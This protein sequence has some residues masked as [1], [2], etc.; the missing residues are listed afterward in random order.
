MGPFRVIL[1]NGL[2]MLFC[3][4]WGSNLG[5]R[6]L[7]MNNAILT[8]GFSLAGAIVAGGLALALG[9]SIP[10]A[11]VAAMVV[12][13]AAAQIR[14]ALA[15]AR[16]RRQTAEELAALKTA[17]RAF[18]RA[19]EESSTRLND[20]NELIETRTSEQRRKVVSELQVLESLMR[21]F[22]ANLSEKAKDDD[23][24]A[25]PVPAPAAEATSY[26]EG[27]TDP[28][29]LEMI[30]TSL[31]QNRVDLYLQP[32]VSLPQRKLRFYEA[33]SRLRAEDGTVIMPEQY[34]RVAAPAGL[35][36]V[37]D[38]LLLFRCVQVVRKLTQKQRDMAV[39]CNIA[40]D[41]LR[42]GE[43][44]PQFL[45]YMHHNRDLAGHIVFEFAQSVVLNADAQVEANLAYLANMGFALSMDH[46]T[47]LAMDLEKLRRLGFRH[48]KVRAET[49]T[50]GMGRA[51]AHVA[52]EDFK[53]LLARY[54][55]NL[56]AERVETEKTV[57]ELLDYAVDYAQGFLFGEPRPVR[58]D[59]QKP[60]ERP[61][62]MA[63]II[64]LRRAG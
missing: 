32:I 34:M 2:E 3:Q 36:S 15:G 11:I 39:F 29:L 54:S 42:D 38:N 52:A 47:T 46:V 7:F 17:N 35:M 48:I 63:A 60:A 44:F 20:L 51:Q 37:V 41:T 31:E 9:A 13:L 1:V 8:A 56:I 26:L 5:R 27:V 18:L 45:D 10:L 49:L 57:V 25:A 28:V 58:D 6:A 62:A 43:F 50:G 12:V 59:M 30:R 40:G 19:A 61:D 21:D 53:S 4:H 24:A 14:G 22:A 23:A 16:E 55:I 64:P 33:L